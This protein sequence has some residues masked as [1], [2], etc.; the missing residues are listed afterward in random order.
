LSSVKQVDVARVITSVM[1]RN[2]EA[3]LV[4]APYVIALSSP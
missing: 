3:L 4:N 2:P 1:Q